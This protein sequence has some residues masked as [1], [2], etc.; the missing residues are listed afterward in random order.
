MFK[1]A[2][3]YIGEGDELTQHRQ[4]KKDVREIERE[5]TRLVN[6]LKPSHK[7][8]MIARYPDMLEG[9]DWWIGK[10]IEPVPDWPNETHCL[11]L[12]TPLKDVVFLCNRG[13]FGA[14]AT[15]A[16]IYFGHQVNQTWLDAMV[17]A[18]LKKGSP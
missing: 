8:E 11:H 10:L 3:M 4:L 15:F 17:V 9:R 2:G 5:L 13:D 14:F 6:G 16:Q 18:A 12:K 1:A 7:C